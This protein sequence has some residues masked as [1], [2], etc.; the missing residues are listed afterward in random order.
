[1]E[2]ISGM[3]WAGLIVPHE[4]LAVGALEDADCF[5]GA[6]VE[7]ALDSQQAAVAMLAIPKLTWAKWRK[8]RTKAKHWQS[9]ADGAGQR[10]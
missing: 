7:I 1:M 8:V 3:G 5:A 9:L 10:R 4:P 2:I 6:S